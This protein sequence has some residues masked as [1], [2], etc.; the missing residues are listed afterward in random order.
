MLLDATNNNKEAIVQQEIC[1]LTKGFSKAEK[2]FSNN[3]LEIHPT[4]GDLAGL[5][6]EEFLND[7]SKGNANTKTTLR[8]WNIS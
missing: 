8:R 7:Y 6:K 3:V 5:T 1:T 4:V 2:L